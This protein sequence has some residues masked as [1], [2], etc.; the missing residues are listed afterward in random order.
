MDVVFETLSLRVQP[1]RLDDL[2]GVRAY[3]ADPQVM[4]YFLL[5]LDSEE[6]I[7]AFLAD[8]VAVRQQSPALRRL[9]LFSAFAR[10]DGAFVGSG[11]IEIDADSRAS[12]EIGYMLCREVWGRGYASELARALVAH[13]LRDL[14][15]HRVWGKCDARNLASARVLEKC[16]MQREGL[17]R[18]HV[19]LDGQWRSSLVFGILRQEWEAGQ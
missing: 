9:H 10:T 6:K 15:L 1:V 16:G 5:D 14:G 8:G 11:L 19:W 17:L 18:E 4:R 13:G 2:A 12:A 7:A 3:A